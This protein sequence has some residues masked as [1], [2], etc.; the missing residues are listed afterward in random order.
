[1]DLGA[2]AGA[3]IGN[4]LLVPF[5]VPGISA[6][7]D[8]SEKITLFDTAFTRADL[9]IALGYNSE[10]DAV[11][12]VGYSAQGAF[13]LRIQPVEF[14]EW[15]PEVHAGITSIAYLPVPKY[16][17]GNTGTFLFNLDDDQRID[18]KL[19]TD[20]DV[21]VIIPAPSGSAS[22]GYRHRFGPFASSIRVGVEGSAILAALANTLSGN[23]F[24]LVSAEL[25][26]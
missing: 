23:V 12:F 22:V 3:S 26:L 11:S 20:L 5:A 7:L 2:H 14:F 19:R 16:G 9:G 17:V 25:I 18:I 4:V 6:S 8:L 15:Q 13:G 24:V 10:G 1:L 21:L